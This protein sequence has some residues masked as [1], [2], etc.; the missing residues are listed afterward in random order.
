MEKNRRNGSSVR[1]GGAN[2]IDAAGENG[3][4]MN[5]DAPFSNGTP[6]YQP[7][8]QYAPPINLDGL[9]MTP[10]GK[11]RGGNHIN[12]RPAESASGGNDR[13]GIERMGDESGSERIGRAF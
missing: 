3:F 11:H 4:A 8:P 5:S 6:T 1:A 13:D 9:N 2:Y 7:Q 12:S 10:E